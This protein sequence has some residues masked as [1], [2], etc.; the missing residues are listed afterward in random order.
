MAN[1]GPPLNLPGEVLRPLDINQPDRGVHTRHF[2]IGVSA[3]ATPFSV[4]EQEDRSFMRLR[5]EGI[6]G[7]NCRDGTIDSIH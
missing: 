2:P 1:A 5:E 6:E 7:F 3:H 4:E